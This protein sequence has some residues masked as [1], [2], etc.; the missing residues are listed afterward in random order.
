MTEKEAMASCL[1]EEACAGFTFETAASTSRSAGTKHTVLFKASTEGQSAAPGW[2]AWHKK[3]VLD[4]SPAARLRRAAPVVLTVHVLR[5]SPPVFVVDDFVSDKECEAMLKETLPKMG[6]SVVGGGGTSSWR[7]SYSVN[8]VPDFTNEDHLITGIARR[9][10]AFAREVAGYDVVE[11]VGQEPV[12]AVYYK[13]NGDQYRPHCDGECAGGRYSLGSRVASSLTYC[14]IADQGGYTLFTRTGLKVVPQKRQMLFFGYF[15]NGTV[16][17]GVAMDNGHTEHTGC[18][19]RKG[20]KWIATMCMNRIR[21]RAP[22]ELGA[23]SH[24][25]VSGFVRAAR[26]NPILTQVVSRGRH[27]RQGLVVLVAI[28]QV[29]RL[30]GVGGARVK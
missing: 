6:R 14:T 20:R 27:S 1:E 21:T 24:Q 26:S 12:N 19:L 4:C 30:I 9:K 23:L 13:D 22:L 29:G 15:F 5:E 17:P 8:M 2:H 25:T 28:W 18:P 16:A 10:F 11:G 3:H 7:Q